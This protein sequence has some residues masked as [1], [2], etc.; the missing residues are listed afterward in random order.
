MHI[1]PELIERVNRF[2]A[3]F[4]AARMEASALLPGNPFGIEVRRFGSGVAVKV[5]HPLL[6]SKNRIFGFQPDDLER[7]DDL[8][9]FYRSDGLRFTLTVPPGQ[10]TPALFRRLV[11]A[12][13]WSEGSGTVPAIVPDGLPN[14]P[15]EVLVR[16]S[17]PEEKELYLDLFQQAFAGREETASEYRAFQ[18]AEDALPGGVRYVAEIA[19]MPVG[20]ASFPLI[21]GVGFLGTAG[22]LPD[23]R[24]RG[25]QTAL[26][27]RRIA[28]APGLG[29]DLVLGGDAPGSTSFRNFERAGLRLVPTG[30]AWKEYPP[31]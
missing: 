3:D 9:S 31:L 10:M 12:G 23:Y 8:I 25:V 4:H 13:L 1:T 19:G 5:Q 20:M 2:F 22:V 11:Q 26:I 6:R 24:G 7:L 28:D 29:C 14:P 17:G 16:R 15:A 18:W 30:F 21:D 27:R